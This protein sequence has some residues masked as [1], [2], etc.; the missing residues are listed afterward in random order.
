MEVD[1][2]DHGLGHDVTEAV[3]DHRPIVL[4]RQRAEDEMLEHTV[5]DQSR[6][7]HDPTLGI[8]PR[9]R[10][11]PDR[12]DAGQ[13]GQDLLR[14]GV[15][16]VGIVDED[17]LQAS[18]RGEPGHDSSQQRGR[19]AVEVDEQTEYAELGVLVHAVPADPDSV[20]PVLEGRSRQESLADADLAFD[21]DAGAFRAAQR[22]TNQFEFALAPE[23]LCSVTS[24][25][26]GGQ[27]FSHS[28]TTSRSSCRLATCT[29]R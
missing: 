24:T 14:A 18:S 6:E 27:L 15:E 16:Q 5:F 28:V 21:E 10:D 17:R 25:R 8:G 29:R 22:L 9:H 3:F 23:D 19:V 4:T 2:V 20:A 7:R 13:V 12:A 1:D 11:K 26:G